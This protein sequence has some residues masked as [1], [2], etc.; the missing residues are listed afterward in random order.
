MIYEYGDYR[1]YLKSVLVERMGSNGSYS[2]R[3]LARDIEVNPSHLS[4]IHRGEKNLSLD[5]AARVAGRLGLDH[6]ETEYFCCLVEYAQTKNLD[7]KDALLEKLNRLSLKRK[8]TNVSVDRFKLI[9]DWYHLPILEMVELSDF[10]FSAESVSE[11]LGITKFEA[12]VAI[13]RLERLKLI[14]KSDDGTYKKTHDN[15]VFESDLPSDALR[16]FHS[17][18]LKKAEKSLTDQS[19]QEKYVGSQT[20][21]IHP[22]TLPEARKVIESAMDRLVELF[23]QE[24][25]PTE[26]YHLGFQ[27]FRIT[28]PET[29]TGHDD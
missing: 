16:H 23:D 22:D 25:H 1:Q 3:A 4:S 24:A 14:Q 28:H 2:L 9:S 27:L 26:V 20:F 7:R 21:S 15:L 13:D 8:V 12:S 5:A 18:M 29:R 19:P 17:Q 11:R 10:P 6:R